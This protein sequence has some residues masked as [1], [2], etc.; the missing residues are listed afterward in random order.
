MAFSARV[1]TAYTY[2]VVDHP[3]W[4]AACSIGIWLLRR[5]HLLF[6]LTLTLFS[7]LWRVIWLV[8]HVQCY[9]LLGILVEVRDFL[10]WVLQDV[11]YDTIS[12]VEF[13]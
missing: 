10:F 6:T 13:E 11:S 9:Q 5:S 3:G 12:A 8:S 7:S 2:S 4:Y 1:C